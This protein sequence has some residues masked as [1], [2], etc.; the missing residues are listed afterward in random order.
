M[1]KSAK[2]KERRQEQKASYLAG[3]SRESYK[4]RSALN[5]ELDEDGRAN[6]Q[7]ETRQDSGY[8]CTKYRLIFS[9][10]EGIYKSLIHQHSELKKRKHANPH[11]KRPDFVHYCDLK[12]Q[13]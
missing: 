4:R 6:G 2:R 9:R 3:M 12:R 8:M 13:N 1:P 5:V 10:Y 7:P 11:P